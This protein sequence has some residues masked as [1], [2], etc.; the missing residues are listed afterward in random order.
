[1]LPDCRRKRRP[2]WANAKPK[3]RRRWLDDY[4]CWVELDEHGQVSSIQAVLYDLDDDEVMD[5]AWALAEDD[6][7]R[8][9]HWTPLRGK[10]PTRRVERL[11]FFRRTPRARSRRARRGRARSPGRRNS[12]D[13]GDPHE[14]DLAS[15]EA[16][17]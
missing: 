16:V 7:A 11:R 17:S 4:G 10:Q 15:A 14:H 2:E 3:P 6:A 5:D 9:R 12:A 8:L 13:D 1:M